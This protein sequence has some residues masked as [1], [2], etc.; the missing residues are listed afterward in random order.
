MCGIAGIWNAI[1]TEPEARLSAMLH[2]MQHRGPDGAGTLAFEGGAAGM[3]RLALVDLSD[4]GQQPFWSADRRVALIFNGE[5]YNFREE[6]SRLSQSG[7]TFHSTTDTEVVLRLYLERGLDFVHRLRGM[8]GLA[9][10]D[11]RN[12]APGKLPEL[13][14]VRGPLGVKPLYVAHPRGDHRQIIFA[15]E[16][17]GLLASNLVPRTVDREALADYLARGFVL[18]PRTIIEGVRTVEPGWI[19]RYAP[20]QP[21]RREQF[22]R[23]PTYQPQRETLDEA[24]ERLRSTL[25]ESVALHAMADAPVGAFLSGGIDSTGIVGLM[26]R[27]VADLRTY[28]LRY[29]DVPGHDEADEAA[30]AARTF[31]CNHTMVEVTGKEVRD[32]LPLFASQIDQPSADGLN[33]WIISKA[34][35][36]DV[37]GVLSGVGGDEWFAG[38]PV[39]RRMA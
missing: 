10:F 7:H 17:R 33:T 38:Y 25:D 32:L 26:R 5:M 30:A 34:A 35:A 20:D 1:A 15:S 36:R 29:P 28:T 13:I 24:A 19:E 9:I 11:W 27:H 4:R 31:E 2:A 21:L 16:L 37:K 22:W 39:V 23:M 14:L 8:Y 3:V 18:Q 12:T 6:R